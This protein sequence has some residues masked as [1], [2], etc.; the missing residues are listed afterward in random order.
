MSSIFKLIEFLWLQLPHRDFWWRHVTL[1]YWN[2]SSE[3]NSIVRCGRNDFARIRSSESSEAVRG[4][5]SHSFFRCFSIHPVCCCTKLAISRSDTLFG[6]RT[7]ISPVGFTLRVIRRSRGTRMREKL[8][9][10]SRF[11]LFNWFWFRHSREGG[12]PGLRVKKVH[13]RDLP[14]EYFS[15]LWVVFSNLDSTF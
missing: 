6:A 10:L 9:T 7:T 11:S 15:L 5:I 8:D 12:N 4:I 14:I 2:P 13:W 1:L 3:A